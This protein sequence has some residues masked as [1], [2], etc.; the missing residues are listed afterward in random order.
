SMTVRKFAALFVCGLTLLGCGKK[1]EIYNATVEITRLNVIRKDK[2]GNALTYDAEFSF[3][4]C[5]GTQIEV[6]RGGKD[7]AACIAKHKV[8]DKVPVELHYHWD[9]SG[10]Y[11]YDVVSL[12]GCERPPDPNDEASYRMIR[13]CEPWKTH[14]AEVGF[15]C[16]V[17]PEHALL[18]KCPWFGKQ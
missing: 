15:I 11:D 6:I 3:F 16:R 7:F 12:A 5:P 18:Q 8:G 9:Q 14:G 13:E 4:E 1:D 10:S 2:A 17:K